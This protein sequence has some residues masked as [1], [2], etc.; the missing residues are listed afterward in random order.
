M[1]SKVLGIFASLFL[2][3]L[4]GALLMTLIGNK[5]IEDIYQSPVEQVVVKDSVDKKQTLLERTQYLKLKII[6][7]KS[8][9]SRTEKELQLYEEILKSY[10][11]I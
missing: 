1:N 10:E 4:L 3:L 8:D 2:V 11:E 6:G 9:L 5:A 7:L